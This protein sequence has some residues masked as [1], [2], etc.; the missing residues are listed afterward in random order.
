[1]KAPRAPRPEPL[2]EAQRALVSSPA[3]LAM[4]GRLARRFARRYASLLGYDDFLGLA[5]LGLAQAARSFDPGFGMPFEGFAWSR[6]YGAL[7]NEVKGEV[8]RGKAVRRGAS[9][10]LDAARDEGDPFTDEPVTQRAQLHAFSDAVLAAALLGVVGEATRH[11][12]D[13]GEAARLAD[14]GHRVATRALDEAIDGLAPPAP[15]IVRAVYF[16]GRTLHDAA[17]ALGI[18]YIAA[19]RHHQKALDRLGVHLRSRGVAA[20]SSPRD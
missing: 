11:A 9:A 3:A 7:M 18:P 6:V 8:L 19:R 17:T 13:S 5:H 2:S 20:P 4:A 10:A 12:A 1:M 15:A 16:E 14:A